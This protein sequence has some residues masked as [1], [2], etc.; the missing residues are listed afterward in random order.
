MNNTLYNFS[1]TIILSIIVLLSSTIVLS[2]NKT[3]TVKNGIT[4]KQAIEQSKKQIN[5]LSNSVLL[6]RL[7][8][9]KNS[10]SA[11]RKGGQHKKADKI[12]KKQFQY[13]MKIVNGFKTKFD[14]CPTY[15]FY[16]DCSQAVLDKE[17]DKVQFLNDSLQYDTTITFNKTTFLTAEFGIIEQDTMQYF[18]NFYYVPGTEDG[19]AK[20]SKY[21]GATNMTFGALIIKSD[22]FVQ[23]RKPFPYYSRTL[24]SLPI[25]C[26]PKL[27]VEEMNIRLHR[28]QKRINNLEN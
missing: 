10:I 26:K 14:F 15:F 18:D 21:N 3:A 8:T 19:L 7:K 16:S 23:L 6:V 20:R 28:F 1:K 9:R 17:F 12:E 5:Q 4:R 24:Y 22:L 11:L 13:N 2:Q 27:V 25:R